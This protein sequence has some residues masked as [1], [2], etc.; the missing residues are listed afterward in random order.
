L[1]S[2]CFQQEVAGEH[3][4]LGLP[5]NAVPFEP[6]ERYVA[7]NGGKPGTCRADLVNRIFLLRL[8]ILLLLPPISKSTRITLSVQHSR[9]LVVAPAW[10]KRFLRRSIVTQVSMIVTL[11][12]D[13]FGSRA[14]MFVAL[15]AYNGQGACRSS[16]GESML[17]PLN[18]SRH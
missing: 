10:Q 9:H 12:R 6:I 8:L 17:K 18:C 14:Q 3:A 2:C 7:G 1:E 13:H 4:W 5:R 11:K 15:L 16:V